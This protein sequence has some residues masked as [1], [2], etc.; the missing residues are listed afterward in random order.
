MENLKLVVEVYKSMG[1]DRII[2]INHYLNF[3]LI[4]ERNEINNEIAN[5]YLSIINK[6]YIDLCKWSD[7][8][9]NL[10]IG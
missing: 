3:I 2:V 5:F 4:E 8:I 1:I 7:Y 10:Q 6:L 9:P